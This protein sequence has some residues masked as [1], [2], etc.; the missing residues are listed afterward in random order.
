MNP[1]VAKIAAFALSL[2]IL[3]Y[4]GYQAWQAFYDPYVTNTV[5]QETYVQNQTLNGFFVREETVIDG[6]LSG[7]VSYNYQNAEKV[8]KNAVIASVYD[9]QN[10]LY[11]LRQIELLQQRRDS[12]AEVQ[13]KGSSEGLKLDLLAKQISDDEMALIQT[14]DQNDF[15]SLNAIYEDLMSSTNKFNICV[16]KDL[17]FESQIAS[18]DQQIATL[19]AQV[20]PSTDAIST[21]KSGYFSS[22]V[23]GWEAQLTPDM[24]S[25]LTI[26]EAA[27]ILA[28][29]TAATPPDSIGRIMTRDTWYFVALM[30]AREAQEYTLGGTITL[31]FQSKSLRQIP[32]TVKQ[33]I[34]EKGNDQAVVVLSSSYLD[35]NF[36][37]MRFEKPSAELH[38]YTGIII[39]KE[40][41]RI[42]KLDNGEGELVDTKVVYVQV[43][44]SVK[45]RLLNVI[46]ED[47][48]III[49][50]VVNDSNY[51]AMYDQVILKGKDLD[52]ISTAS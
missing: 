47:E 13:D 36:V 49:S 27:D 51:V 29:Q 38:K 42:R 37:T 33:I 10:D 48:D 31:S 40:A 22:T 1:T 14:V 15:S 20:S 39:P 6:T 5:Y 34:T 35:E 52:V 12:L 26:D 32:A 28:N 50:K 30:T 24:L 46:Y 16:D 25:D 17:S 11:L 18:L 19:K 9:S 41:V 7:V 23:D 2:F 21:S 44:L 45:Y 4:V 43:G 8:A 3:V